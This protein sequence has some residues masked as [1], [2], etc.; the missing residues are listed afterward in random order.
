MALMASIHRPE[1]SFMTM[2]FIGLGAFIVTIIATW[3]LATARAADKFKPVQSQLEARNAE[4]WARLRILEAT[5]VAR[6]RDDPVWLD[7][8][9]TD[10]PEL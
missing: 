7:E 4:L 6:W 2:F 10:S 9:R 1:S 8:F 3:R 5:A